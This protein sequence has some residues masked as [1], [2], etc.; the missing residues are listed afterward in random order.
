MGRWSALLVLGLLAAIPARA[1]VVAT[2]ETSSDAE[3]KLSACDQ[4]IRSGDWSG[5]D[6]AWAY[7]NRGI[8]YHGRGDYA[9]AIKDYDKAIDLDPQDARAFY[10]R[11]ISFRRLGQTDRAIIDYSQA[12]EIDPRYGK[13]Y[14]NRG[15]AHEALGRFDAAIQDTEK[16][17]ELDGAWRV[18]ALQEHLAENGYDTVEIDGVYGPATRDALHACIKAPGC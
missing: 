5:P 15:I 7:N 6:L 17:I 1:D 16:A 10:N 13:A 2:C 12:I 8:A 9:R 4:V 11:G 14:Y 3:Q 18:R